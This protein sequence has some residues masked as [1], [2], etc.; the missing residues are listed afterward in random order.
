LVCGGGVVAAYVWRNVTA[1]AV[2]AGIDGNVNVS[3]RRRPMA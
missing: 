3:R 1:A 2:S